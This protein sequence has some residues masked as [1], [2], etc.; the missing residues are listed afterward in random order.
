MSTPGRSRRSDPPGLRAA[1]AVRARAARAVRAR[2]ARFLHVRG[3]GVTSDQRRV[4]TSTRRRLFTTP[5]PRT[6][7]FVGC[8]RARAARE[9]VVHARCMRSSRILA[10]RRSPRMVGARVGEFDCRECL[11]QIGP[12]T[13]ASRA[14]APA[15]FP[16]FVRR[17]WREVHAQTQ[18]ER[19]LL[20]SHERA[21][22][23]ARN[24]AA[25]ASRNTATDGQGH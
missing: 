25:H 4:G 2:A 3:S 1:R 19:A 15:P 24:R 22:E 6:P 18:R 9:I 23:N 13:V 16:P 11:S 21:G 10:A 17:E 20:A 8:L 5:D 7:P 12:V 14:P